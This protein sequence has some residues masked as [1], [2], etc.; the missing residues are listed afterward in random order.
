MTRTD[1]EQ[2]NREIHENL[3]AWE[4]KPLLQRIY[5][6]FH[7]AI[8]EVALPAEAGVTVELGSGIGAIQDTLPHCLRTDIFP[9][10]WID[11][12]ETTYDLSFEDNS[13]ANII[14]FDVFHH[15][16]YPGTALREFQ[17]VLIPGGRVIIF[18][19]CLSLLGLLV[20]GALHH[21]PLGLGDAIEWFA[22][23]GWNHHDDDYYAA[24]GNAFRAFFLGRSSGVLTNWEV[25]HKRRFSAISYVASGG[26]RKPQLYPER[27]YPLMKG[28]DSICDLFPLLLQLDC[29]WCCGYGV[30]RI[31]RLGGR[32]HSGSCTVAHDFNTRDDIVRATVVIHRRTSDAKSVSYRETTASHE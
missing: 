6:E 4:A 25:V 14:L 32:T 23:S 22:P 1:L 5:R 11:Q 7:Q 29:S 19:P 2:H 24:Q 30:N 17:R 27:L 18:D 12:V 15:I 16:H 28:V 9:N 21:E 31:V 10:P 3:R 13:V 8:G 26:Y 20:Y